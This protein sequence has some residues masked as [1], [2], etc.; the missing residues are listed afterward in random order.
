MLTFANPFLK[1]CKENHPRLSAYA[2]N[3]E[4][5]PIALNLFK[6]NPN[7]PFIV[8]TFSL[9][10]FLPSMIISSLKSREI[11]NAKL[12]FPCAL[13]KFLIYASSPSLLYYH[14]HK[15]HVSSIM[16][17]LSQLWKESTNKHVAGKKVANNSTCWRN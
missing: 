15:S 5:H 3:S 6:F 13:I 12:K 10:Y 9:T 7:N 11:M 2:I 4:F 16:I 8:T 14:K 1:N 17:I